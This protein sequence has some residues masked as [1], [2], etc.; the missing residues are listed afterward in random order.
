MAYY[1]KDA[2]VMDK[3]RNLLEEQG[4]PLVMIR[5]F[6]PLMGA[7]S[8]QVE[9]EYL[10]RAVIDTAFVALGQQADTIREP[11]RTEIVARIEECRQE[12]NK[13]LDRRQQRQG[14]ALD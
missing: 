6:V 4:M 8:V 9:D 3:L 13:R 7:V 1:P 12:I 5:K 10:C 14:R 2:A 11:E